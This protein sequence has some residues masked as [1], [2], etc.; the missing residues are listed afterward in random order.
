MLWQR[1][2]KNILL[3]IYE[4]CLHKIIRPTWFQ[5]LILNPLTVFIKEGNKNR[6][7]QGGDWIRTSQGRREVV[8]GEMWCRLAQNPPTPSSE[9][10]G[11][12]MHLLIHSASMFEVLSIARGQMWMSYSLCLTFPEYRLTGLEGTFLVNYAAKAWIPCIK[13]LLKLY[14]TALELAIV[15][16]YR[17]FDNYY[18]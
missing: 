12:L 10:S 2:K 14:T 16:M 5:G 3:L 4:N 18:C 11:F 6:P 1:Q 17:L 7:R 15:K 13:S 8:A 9:L